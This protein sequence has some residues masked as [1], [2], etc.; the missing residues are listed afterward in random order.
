MCPIAATHSNI[1][2]RKNFFKS[3]VVFSLSSK[4]LE[5]LSR[6]R[7]HIMQW[8][9]MLQAAPVAFLD[10]LDHIK[11][12]I[13]SSQFNFLL[14]PSLTVNPW[15]FHLSGSLNDPVFTTIGMFE[16]IEIWLVIKKKK[17]KTLLK[18]SSWLGVPIFLLNKTFL[19][20]LDLLNT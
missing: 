2:K 9:I 19:Y 4:F 20:C 1:V 12:I 15:T 11:I 3:W 8:G 14:N 18:M 17:I 13:T 5:F 10:N 7:F 6:Q 16:W